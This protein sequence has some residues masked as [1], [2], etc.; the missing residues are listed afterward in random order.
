MRFLIGVPCHN[1]SDQIANVIDEI[2]FEMAK[3]NH[4]FEILVYD[5]G[6]TDQTVSA[7]SKRNVTIISSPKRLGLGKVFSE[8]RNFA[9]RNNFDYLIT[10]DGDNQFKFSDLNFFFSDPD[11]FKEFTLLGSRFTPNSTR[12]GMNKSKYFGNKFIAKLI[13][14]LVGQNISDASCGFRVYPISHLKRLSVTSVFTYTHESILSIAF[15]GMLL[16]SF[17]I[18]VIY[19]ESR[20]SRQANSVLL[21]GLKAIKIILLTVWVYKPVSSNIVLALFFLILTIIFGF[22]PFSNFIYYGSVSPYIY[23]AAMSFLSL[24]LGLIH[25]TVS[26]I[27]FHINLS[28]KRIENLF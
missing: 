23:L 16:R 4:D 7:I 18:Q 21:Y 13:S 2:I 22:V 26:L 9:T 11:N 20:I 12:I 10:I 15:Q 17:P 3:F 24:L 5:D 25:L 14:F 19:H 8:I 1:E 27:L 6:S 28:I